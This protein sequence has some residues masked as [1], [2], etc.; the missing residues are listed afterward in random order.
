MNQRRR[1]ITSILA[2]WVIVF[3][4]GVGTGFYI[5]DRQ[6]HRRLEEAVQEIRE[7]VEDAGLEALD[8]ARQAGADLGAG[9]GAAAESTKAV[10][11]RLLRGSDNR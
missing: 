1:G 2:P 4:L 5:R 9:A 8:R 11:R 3:G 6:Q 10:F 7:D